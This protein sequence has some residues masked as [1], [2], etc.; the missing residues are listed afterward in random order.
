MVA[1]A[2]RPAMA[3]GLMTARSLADI[4]ASLRR[5]GLIGADEETVQQAIDAI[6]SVQ[7]WYVRTMIGFGALG[8]ASHRGAASMGLTLLIGVGACL[9]AASVALPATL[10]LLSRRR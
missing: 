3:I 7:P 8:F 9:L 1:P 10:A 6:A 4:A 5:D 2:G